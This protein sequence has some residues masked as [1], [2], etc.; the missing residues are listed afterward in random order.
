M[1]VSECTRARENVFAKYG[2]KISFRSPQDTEKR[3]QKGIKKE[4]RRIDINAT[5]NVYE[6]KSI[7]EDKAR[8]MTLLLWAMDRELMNRGVGFKDPFRKA[9][10]REDILYKTKQM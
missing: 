1:S 5:C 7:Q 4:S 10:D 6:S 3:N 9:L 8:H 2:R